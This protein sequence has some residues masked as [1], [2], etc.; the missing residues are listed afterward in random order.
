MSVEQ[1]GCTVDPADNR[2][3]T[4]DPAVGLR[5]RMLELHSLAKDLDRLAR[6][7]TGCGSPGGPRPVALS[8]PL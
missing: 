1:V 3:A 8:L 5:V 4:A 6:L 2:R 7:F